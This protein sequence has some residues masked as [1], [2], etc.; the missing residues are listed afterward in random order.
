M[1]GGL[2]AVAA[3]G[4]AGADRREGDGP[5]DELGVAR[6]DV[7]RRNFLFCKGRKGK[8]RV[9]FFFPGCFVFFIKTLFL[10]LPLSKA[11]PLSP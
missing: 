7:V 5:R 2:A 4:G 6:G 1:L 3:R 10:F 8:E 9:S 11:S